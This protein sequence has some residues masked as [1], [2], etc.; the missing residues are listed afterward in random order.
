MPKYINEIQSM[1]QYMQEIG[2]NS[3]GYFIIDRN[4]KVFCTSSSEPLK[5]FFQNI[6][7]YYNKILFSDKK[8]EKRFYYYYNFDNNKCI[9]TILELSSLLNGYF[10][11]YNNQSQEEFV[12]RIEYI[13]PQLHKIINYYKNINKKIDIKQFQY[14]YHL[15]E[16]FSSFTIQSPDDQIVEILKN[17]TIKQ[18][19]IFDYKGQSVL[20]SQKQ[21]QLL[22]AIVQGLSYE[23]IE[24]K[25]GIKRRSSNLYLTN[26]KY[27]TGW[28]NKAQL[29]SAFLAM[30]P[31][32]NEEYKN[33]K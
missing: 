4:C 27:K 29:I 22:I 13:K 11:V 30:N 20:L 1:E 32:F 28:K 3:Y 31:W 17:L 5:D 14:N 6:F 9:F 15:K 33:G 19:P 21:S 16:N 7:N 2:V 24:N 18:I 10:F 26:I 12:N 25:Y 23:E 8:S